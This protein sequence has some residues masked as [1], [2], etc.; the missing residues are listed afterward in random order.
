[1]VGWDVIAY[2]AFDELPV[3]YFAPWGLE[4]SFGQG[5]VKKTTLRYADGWRSKQGGVQC[6]K[7]AGQLTGQCSK[8]EL[9]AEMRDADMARGLDEYW[10]RV[11]VVSGNS[12]WQCLF[13][14]P[15]LN[16]IRIYISSSQKSFDSTQ[17]HW[18][19]VTWDSQINA[20]SLSRAV[21]QLR[22]IN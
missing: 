16:K 7:A 8:W 9:L 4:M 2:W 10:L 14:L 20:T 19:S 12:I 3:W 15:I 1:M 13:T 11:S 18:N 5:E 17:C 6:V 22:G 21:R